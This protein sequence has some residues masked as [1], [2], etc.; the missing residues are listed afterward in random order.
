MALNCSSRSLWVADDCASMMLGC[1][2]WSEEAS[3]L[4]SRGVNSLWWDDLELEEEESDPV[5]LLPTDPFGMNLETTFTA[6]IASCI[7]DLTG[8]SG[9]GHLGSGDDDGFY[10]D[11]SYY[12]NQAFV[13]TP[14]PWSGAY[15]SVFEDSFVSGCLSGAGG[16]EQ[17]SR[18]P[19]SSFCSEPI[20]VTDDPSSSC[21]TAL[22]CCDMVDVAPVQEGNDAHEAMVFV[23]S[24]LGLRDILSIEMVCKSLRSA[25]RNEPFLWKCIHIDSH[26][27]EK[28]SDADLLC[29]TQKSPG[30]LQCLSLMCCVNITDQGLKAVLESNLQLTK[31]GIFGAFRITHQGLV[32]SLRSFS[33][34]ADIGIK[35]LRVANRVTAS[36]VQYVELLSLMKIDKEMPLHKQ[37]PRIFHADRLLPDLH[38]GY[39]PDSFVPDLHDEYALD[40]EKCPLCPNYKLV[41][42]CTSKE[43]KT[44]G[45]SICRG[46]VVCISRCLRCGRCIDSEFEFE[47]TFFLGSICHDC[48]KYSPHHRKIDV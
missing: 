44:S 35:K 30:S 37:E 29:L 9:A 27:G 36:E 10:A 5:D 19:P 38:G 46:C 26:L 28:M 11:L 21:D 8:M 14:E 15:T 41:Y 22:P 12:L 40:I 2:C 43:C 18:L 47:E 39:V 7:G 32:D 42:D 31:L 25:V 6:A 20:G 23:L 45:S 13:L 16:M 4:S 34:E 33:M 1:G 17:F 24:Y 48:V 3:P